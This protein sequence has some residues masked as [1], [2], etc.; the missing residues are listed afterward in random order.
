[1]YQ[2]AIRSATQPFEPRLHF[3]CVFHNLYHA[4]LSVVHFAGET[5]LCLYQQKYQKLREER[6]RAANEDF[7]E[8]YDSGEDQKN[9][10]KKQSENKKNKNVGGGG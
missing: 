10:N 4:S 6:R 9:D 1:M 5:P 2:F 3:L 8:N 7:I